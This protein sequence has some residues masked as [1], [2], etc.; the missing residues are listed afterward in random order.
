V[1]LRDET[2]L[3]IVGMPRSGT[4]LVERIVSSH[5]RAT[6][7][8]ELPFWSEEGPAWLEAP[9]DAR[10]GRAAEVRAA[11]LRVLRA[12][13]AGHVLRATDKMPFNFFWLGLVHRLF[14]RARFVHCR[15]HPVDTCLSIYTTQFGV[16]WPFAS[17]RADLALYYR[18]YA[19][20]MD[21][22]RAV[23]PPERLL[24]VD[25]EDVVADPDASA[26][27][28]VAFAGLPWDD[29]C[30]A[31]EKNPDAVR[32]AN[33]WQARQPVYRTSTERWRRYEPWLGE[34]RELLAG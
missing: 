5:P 33:K 23:I 13:T 4:T 34:L 29:A 28:L 2:P 8:G 9:L 3:L 22:W 25:Y 20:L 26:R 1:I 15:R 30:L 19:R 12:G 17:S 14:P 10:S 18:L 11:Y 31:P 27:R 32:T 24:E 6:G 21:H 7:R 16:S